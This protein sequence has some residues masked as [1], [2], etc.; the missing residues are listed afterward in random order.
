MT[1]AN[2]YATFSFPN[3]VV[4]FIACARWYSPSAPIYLGTSSRNAAQATVLM[5]FNNAPAGAG[6]H[7]LF[8]VH[9]RLL[10]CRNP[11]GEYSQ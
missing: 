5:N 3:A 7:V 1:N 11:R 6:K 2:G 4:G 9:R 8:T 10:Q